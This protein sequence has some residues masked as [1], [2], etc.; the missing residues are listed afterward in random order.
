MSAAFPGDPSTYWPNIVE[1]GE[2]RSWEHGAT[3]GRLGQDD[4]GSGQGEREARV[5]SLL[6]AALD[7]TADGLLV[8][9]R[10]GRVIEFNE[11]FVHAWRLPPELVA[12]RDDARL[13]AF[14]LAELE[15]PD[16]FVAGVRA[17]YA[18]PDAS[19]FDVLRFRDGR[20]FE[21]YSQPA[22][23]DGRPV[24]RV[25][26]FRDVTH[27]KRTEEALRR[28][29]A[30]LLVLS[31]V[32]RA[33]AGARLDLRAILDSVARRLA[34][35]LGDACAIRI[36][37]VDGASVELAA[38]HHHDERVADI[39]RT[40]L[41]GG[42]EPVESAFADPPG[43]WPLLVPA[44]DPSLLAIVPEMFH[45]LLEGVRSLLVVPMRIGGRIIGTLTL[46]RDR[47]ALPF[48][49]DDATLVE[50]IA[51][52]AA[53]AID[54]ARLYASAQDA[55]RARDDFLSI[56][57]HELRTPVTSLLLGLQA[58]RRGVAPDARPVVTSGE[59]ERFERQ[60]GRLARLVDD[61]LDI[62][63]VRAGHLELE[64]ADVDLTALVHDVVEQLRPQSVR[65]GCAVTCEAE[66]PVVGRWD[67]ARIE[68]VATNLVGNAL[69]YGAGRPVQV[70]VERDGDVARLAVAD[71]G[72]GVAP[73]R[74]RDI[75]EPYER[76]A[77]SRHYGGLGLGLFIVRRVVEAHG[78]RVLVESA[79]G[80]G[81]RFVVELP[82]TPPDE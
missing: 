15:D 69:K 44:V 71:R 59:L 82:L 4:G 45:P 20:V 60:A 2:R 51:N 39:A 11:R 54:N 28:Q 41:Q 68:Q 25:W 3:G 8:V 75:F 34:E 38:I 62:S 26:S 1:V 13:V 81:A 17:L 78:G 55:V 52:R 18:T 36:A 49:P 67:R 56:A 48:T 23:I 37:T 5:Q 31:E 24:G 61:L 57:A 42:L 53:L 21:R 65:A 58:K 43:G 76:A 35:L 80:D 29:T 7:S 30:G 73:E 9:D 70:R 33:M 64:R 27:V 77:S 72:I 22:R 46:V 40:L 74:H 66:G 47:T 6:R 16:A 10:A 50:E 79:A 12:T 19:S 14:V 63:R 32:S